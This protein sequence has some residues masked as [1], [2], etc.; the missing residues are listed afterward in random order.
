VTTQERLAVE[1]DE[2]TDRYIVV[3]CDTHT[4][5]SVREHLRPYC[6]AKHLA[7]FD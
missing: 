5:P 2:V 3:S 1:A 6:E 7:V 4:G